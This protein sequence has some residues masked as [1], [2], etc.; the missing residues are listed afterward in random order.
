VLA[1]GLA[2]KSAL[3][4]EEQMSDVAIAFGVMGKA[5][6]ESLAA[7]E[8]KA[9]EL[10]RT[11]RFTAAQA[12][13]SLHTLGLGGLSVAQAMSTLDDVMNLAAATGLE[14]SASA[15]MVID[16][17]IKYGI[18]A[19]D[20]TRIVDNLAAAQNAV[21]ISA[22]N[23]AEAHRS[24]G[25]TT[26]NMG[27]TF[28]DTSKILLGIMKSGQLP[29]EAGTALGVGL[30]R[31]IQLPK[32]AKKGIKELGL[33]IDRFIDKEGRFTDTGIVG[34][35]EEMA[36]LDITPRHIADVF[37]A[38]GRKIG[39]IFRVIQDDMAGRNDGWQQIKKV[40]DEVGFAALAAGFK[41]ERGFG[42]LLKLWSA[43]SELALQAANSIK[44]IVDGMTQL[45]ISVTGML[46]RLGTGLG[47]FAE[48]EAGANS[49]KEALLEISRVIDAIQPEDFKER[50]EA[51]SKFAVDVF[52]IAFKA[53]FKIGKA[54]AVGIGRV[55]AAEILGAMAKVAE[56]TA[57]GKS[58]IAEGVI[59]G[60]EEAA[61][62]L[63]PGGGG[64]ELGDDLRDDLRDSMEGAFGAP[65]KRLRELEDEFRNP[66]FGPGNL[67]VVDE[68]FRTIDDLKREVRQA[69][70]EVGEPVGDPAAQ[71][72]VLISD[73]AEII[74]SLRDQI[75]EELTSDPLGIVARAQA[76]RLGPDHPLF[77]NFQLMAMAMEF[78][79]R[80]F[81]K[82][83]QDEDNLTNERLAGMR[84][85]IEKMRAEAEALIGEVVK[86][87]AEKPEEEELGKQF[88]QSQAVA[89]SALQAHFQGLNQIE[90][91]IKDAIDEG[92]ELQGEG[93]DILDD[94]ADNT[95]NM[96]PGGWLG[97]TAVGG[98]TA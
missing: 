21:Q 76:D 58:D 65:A 93:N 59:R 17:M 55:L 87:P 54:V 39:G 51:L 47:I 78:R 33:E 83:A 50:L 81:E 4:F 91:E 25:A 16:N 52:A 46:S 84:G 15:Q 13:K 57:E 40:E 32:E 14:L 29:G 95:A 82:V 71:A 28:E 44:P 67:P 31:L 30:G 9:M 27:A 5:G 94:I 96:T 98:F 22:A 69:V 41:M 38:R 77:R 75:R 68:I 79:L 86:P 74:G 7:L 36:R 18:A 37:G 10:G 23:L 20:T 85:V 3:G 66:Q 90:Q 11:T 56:A 26:A 73:M 1:A 53:I 43:I 24:L 6:E 72:K 49:I 19:N 35:F 89:A 34:L 88:G 61:R 2:V 48:F 92:N 64:I 45:M 62:T 97:G 63:I 80:D 60:I 12:A 70:R 8:A 42:P